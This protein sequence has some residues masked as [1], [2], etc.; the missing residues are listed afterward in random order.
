MRIIKV[1]VLIALIQIPFVFA[2][3]ARDKYYANYIITQKIYDKALSTAMYDAT[4]IINNYSK[5]ELV[6]GTPELVIDPQAVVN[7]FLESFS[8]QMTGA[9]DSKAII[10]K[11]PIIA[12]ADVDGVYFYEVT[13]VNNSYQVQYYD[14]KEYIRYYSGNTRIHFYL[15]DHITVFENNIEVYDGYFYDKEYFMPE[16]M[17]YEA[18]KMVAV[19]QIIENK[20]NG[21]VSWGEFNEITIPVLSEDD[22]IKATADISIIALVFE[23]SGQRFRLVNNCGITNKFY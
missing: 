22:W 17:D 12:I 23:E 11:V 14:K 21:Y 19:A 16:E 15:N 10:Y 1:I 6:E 20:M 9:L 4:T 8:V 18:E 7:T 3:Y 5:I 13:N 2:N